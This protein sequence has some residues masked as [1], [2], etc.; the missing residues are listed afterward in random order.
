MLL[1]ILFALFV[2]VPLIEIAVFIQLGGWLGLIP[3]LLL[4]VLTAIIG[5]AL[6]RQQGFSV[7]R[8]AQRNLDSGV[9]PVR[10]LFD[11][12]CLLITGA[13]L[14]TPGFVTDGIGGALLLPPV[15]GLLY[16]RVKDRLAS[17]VVRHGPGQRPPQQGG[18][19]DG[20][21][22]VDYEVIEQPDAPSSPP[23]PDPGKG[24]RQP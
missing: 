21:I 7:L 13:L 22:D 4:V 17:R 16:L 14:L 19:Q 11:G 2:T 6:I 9:V 20:T 15:R 18:Q 10:E 23:P 1:L 8:R 12:A 5:S 24:W 3:T